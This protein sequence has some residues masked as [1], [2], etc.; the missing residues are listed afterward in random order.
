MMVM[1]TIF[2]ITERKRGEEKLRK[3]YQEIK[4]LKDRLQ[5]ETDYL[6]GEI[7]VNYRHGEIIGESAAIQAVIRQVEQVAPT[8]SSVLIYGETGVGKEVVARA[9]HNLSP[10]KDRAMV[11]VNCASLPSSLVESELF[12][13]EKGAYTG[14]MSRQPGRF[15][16]ADGSTILLDE[17]AELSPE[18]Q[19]KLLRVLQEGEFERLGSPNTI[20]VDVRVIAATN[21]NLKEAVREGK[22]REDL[23][24]RL[25]V[26]PIEIPPL[27][28][29]P[30]DI[31]LLVWTF[32]EELGE[33]MGRKIPPLTK[34][35]LE[36]LQCYH[37]PGNVRE[38]R[39]VIENAIIISS[40]KTLQVHL[41]KAPGKVASHILTLQDAE[42]QHISEVLEMTHWRV[43]GA[44]GAAELLGLHPST[45]HS[46]MRKLGIPFRREKD[47]ISSN[48]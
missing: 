5:A 35:T 14:A 15:E 13:R 3:S 23:Y 48:R 44:H 41:P 28:E 42:R 1:A 30:E 16:V 21:R 7:K 20:K 17:I 11:K 34:R 10:R 24:Y 39:N 12:G 29:R 8:N 19:A 36:T 46:K 26:F 4:Q 37:W 40:G 31:P 22:F 43:K 2:D 6:R 45:L 27:R 32:M 38:V 33:K 18:L 47:D 25:N 9:I